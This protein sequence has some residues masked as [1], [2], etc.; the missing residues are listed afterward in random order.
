MHFKIVFL[1]CA[2]LDV[3]K[4][5]VVAAICITDPKTLLEEYIV[6][7]RTGQNFVRVIMKPSSTRQNRKKLF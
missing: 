5:K 3:H 6:R 2:G 4:K 7:D 1:I